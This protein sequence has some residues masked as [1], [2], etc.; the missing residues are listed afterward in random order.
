[1]IW[2]IIYQGTTIGLISLAAY[3]I[4]LHD[5]KQAG[6]E[7][8]EVL[9]RT[10][11]F[12]V[13]GFSQLLHVR[14]LHSNKHSSFRTSVFSNLALLGAIFMSALLLLGVLLIPSVSNIFGVM[15]MDNLHWLYVGNLSLVPCSG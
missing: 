11:A 1:M 2:R 7:D 12:A 5:G 9:G 14:N 4:G 3:L 15:P 8:P 13:L 10:M 6:L